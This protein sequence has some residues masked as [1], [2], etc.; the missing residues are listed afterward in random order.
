MSKAEMQTFTSQLKNQR[1]VLTITALPQD[2]SSRLIG[3][4]YKIILPLMQRVFYELGERLTTSQT[5]T[6][7]KEIAPIMIKEEKRDGK[8]IKEIR[9]VE[10]LADF[11]LCEFIDCI[12]YEAA[13]N[14]AFLEDSKLI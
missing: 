7:L 11:E 1:M 2:R 5:E 6:K 12:K 8:W 10:D 13:E 3:Y 4:Y 9:E 14:G